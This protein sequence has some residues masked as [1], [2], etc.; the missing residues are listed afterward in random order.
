MTYG[1]VVRARA[2]NSTSKEV[3]DPRFGTYTSIAISDTGCGMDEA[4]VQKACER[5]FST[6]GSQQG[7]GL[8]LPLVHGLAQQSGGKIDIETERGVGTTVRLVLP[9]GTETSML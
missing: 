9:A 4:T 1:G 6:K 8:G 7:T 2:S 5:F 3:T